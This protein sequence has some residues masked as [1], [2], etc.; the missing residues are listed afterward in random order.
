MIY[1]DPAW[2]GDV[3]FYEL[4]FGSWLTYIFLVLLFEKVLRAP[5]Q[6][7]K[8]ILLTF[9]GCF[10]FWVNHYFQGADFIWCCSMPIPYAFFLP[11][12]LSRLSTSNG[13]F[14]GRLQPHSVPLYSQSLLSVSN[15]SPASASAQVSMNSGSC[16]GQLLV[17]SELFFGEARGKRQ[18]I[19]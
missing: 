13:E 11:G 3:E 1:I 15:T 6:E 18:K 10:A 16:S 2:Q 9:L 8:Y 19:T 17:S 7:W 5:L 4:I 12:T 14:S